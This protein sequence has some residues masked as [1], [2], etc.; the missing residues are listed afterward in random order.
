MI[1]KIAFQKIWSEGQGSDQER[2]WGVN[3]NLEIS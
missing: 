2:H 1:S 3:K